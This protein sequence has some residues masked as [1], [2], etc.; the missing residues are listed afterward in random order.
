MTTLI[1]GIEIIRPPVWKALPMFYYTCY[2]FRHMISRV[3][4]ADLRVTPRHILGI[5]CALWCKSNKKA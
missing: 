4:S 2:L 5:G 3:P 1:T